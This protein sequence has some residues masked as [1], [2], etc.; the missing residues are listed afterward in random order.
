[1]VCMPPC[2]AVLHETASR[3]QPGRGV[4]SG[5]MERCRT[6]RHWDKENKSLYFSNENLGTC[7]VGKLLESG[8]WSLAGKPLDAVVYSYDESGAFATGPD[9]GCVHWE[10]AAPQLD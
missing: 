4:E 3:K 7:K 8:D 1:M 2:Y 10:A 9:F 6:C 5:A